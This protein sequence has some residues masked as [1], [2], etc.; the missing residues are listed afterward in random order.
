MTAGLLLG[1]ALFIVAAVAG[2]RHALYIPAVLLAAA[3][4]AQVLL[5]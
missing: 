4:I 5:P 2:G 1:A 3:A